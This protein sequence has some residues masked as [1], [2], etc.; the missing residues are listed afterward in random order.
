M[1]SAIPQNSRVRV[2]CAT[3]L[4]ATLGGTENCQFNFGGLG[5]IRNLLDAAA[6]Q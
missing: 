6:G 2:G 1:F 4:N 5:A 3:S